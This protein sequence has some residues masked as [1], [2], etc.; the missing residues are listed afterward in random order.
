MRPCQ[1]KA[2]TCAIII[3]SILSLCTSSFAQTGGVKRDPGA[4]TKQALNQAS[5]SGNVSKTQD[6][7]GVR[8]K[9]GSVVYGIIVD[10]NINNVTI[11]T[12]DNQMVRRKFDDVAAFIRSDEKESAGNERDWYPA[13]LSRRRDKADPLYRLDFG[14]MYWYLD[15]KEDFPPPGKSEEKGWLPGFYLSWDYNKKN[16]IY[17]KVFLEF[18][19]GDVTYD[20]TTQTG[21]PITFSDDNHQFFFRGEINLGYNFA[22]TQNISIKPYTGYGYR[23]WNRGQTEIKP[24]SGINVLSIQEQYYWHYIP[25]GVTADFQITDR[26]SVE[27]NVG[28]RLMFYGK[29]TVEY[30]DFDPG[31]N[32]PDVK[33]GNR[34]G[35]Y[36]EIPLRYKLS[37]GWAVVLKPWYAYDQIG[38]SDTVD[39][40]FNGVPVAS[41][42]EPSSTTHQYGVNLGL[43]FAY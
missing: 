37:Q 23:R 38:Q 5:P 31:F 10:M 22:V 32:S 29:M 28:A 41:L 15:Y 33:L 16:A 35:Y 1:K 20:G 30:S 2:W 27:P 43:S 4:D 11:L 36:A 39:L 24:V 18:S 34:V 42:Y 26:I 12:K 7:R 8:F 6:I 40:T 14:F 9:D 3:T 17:A 19:A 13:S 25:V 21:T